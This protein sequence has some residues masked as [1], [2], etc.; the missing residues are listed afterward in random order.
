M[1]AVNN[2]RD[3]T[4]AD[5]L[6]KLRQDIE[7]AKAGSTSQNNF[8]LNYISPNADTIDITDAITVNGNLQSASDTIDITD[9]VVQTNVNTGLFQVEDD[10]SYQK[11]WLSFDNDVVDKSGNNNSG[12]ITGTE[13]YVSGAVSYPDG[14]YNKAFS[15]DGSTYIAC[16]NESQFDFERTQPFSVSYWVK[17]TGTA[18]AYVTK[19]SGNGTTGWQVDSGASSQIVLRLVNTATTN[20]I[21]VNTGSAVIND[22]NWHHVVM[23]YSGNSLASGVKIY[24]DGVSVAMTTITD[25][26]SATILNNQAIVVGAE[27]V[28]NRKFTGS[29]DDVQI[30]NYALSSSDITTLYNGQQI[31]HNG[32]V[33][34]VAKVEFCDC[35]A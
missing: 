24:I 33:S 1:S 22:G 35:A 27:G 10:S 14:R 23:T 12:T 17:T 29:L 19:N 20:E 7:S 9:A 8:T 11:L 26:L 28:F 4:D 16:S 21:S 34:P 5:I 31:A 30:W 2:F 6:N 25:N 15:F 3:T 32:S 13:T 18:Q